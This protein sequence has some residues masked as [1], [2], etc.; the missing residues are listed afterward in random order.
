MRT[1]FEIYH[2]PGDYFL[3]LRSLAEAYRTQISSVFTAHRELG[4]FFQCDAAWEKVAYD[5]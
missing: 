4:G 3:K 1:F 5:S 2:L